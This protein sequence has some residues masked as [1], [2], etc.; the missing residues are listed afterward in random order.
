MSDVSLPR[1]E[2]LTVANQGLKFLSLHRQFSHRAFQAQHALFIRL[3]KGNT[4][5][6]ALFS[7]QQTAKRPGMVFAPSPLLW[8]VQ[9][10]EGYIG[11]ASRTSRRTG[12]QQSVQSTMER[13]LMAMYDHW[14]EA[15]F[16]RE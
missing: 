13:T 7:L 14:R 11:K 2:A 10:D 8:S 9:I 16:L 4:V 1:S 3:P 15:G 6:H 12:A 5:D